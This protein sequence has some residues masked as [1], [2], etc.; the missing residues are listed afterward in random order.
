MPCDRISV[1]PDVARPGGPV[2]RRAASALAMAVVALGFTAGCGGQAPVVPPPAAVA[3]TTID[4]RWLNAQG[5]HPSS[6]PGY[7]RAIDVVAEVLLSTWWGLPVTPRGAGVVCR[8]RSLTEAQARIL[9]GNRV[10]VLLPELRELSP[11]VARQFGSCTG[12]LDFVVLETLGPAAAA[13]LAGPRESLRLSAVRELDAAT[14]RELSASTCS[15]KLDGLTTLAP[16][17]AAALSRHRGLLSLN[18]VIEISAEDA[19]HLADHRGDLCLNGLVALS[20]EAAT[21]FARFPHALHI[22]SVDTLSAEAAAA[23]ARHPGWCLSCGGLVHLDAEAARAL[24]RHVRSG[25]ELTVA[26]LARLE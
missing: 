17:V 14:A 6:L 11:A 7:G 1:L 13:G 9:A 4:A 5:V 21:A 26:H 24:S 20:A 18:G 10:A 2:R 19:S 25:R 22:N 8:E 15:L 23:L 12:L 16:G 3:P